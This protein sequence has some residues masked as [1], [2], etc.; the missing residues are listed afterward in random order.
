[1]TYINNYAN[2][3][4]TFEIDSE[5]EVSSLPTH[6]KNNVGYHSKAI[7]LATGN[8]YF[9]EESSDTWQLFGGE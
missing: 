1:M 2:Q 5:A 8:V 7:V 4:R 9:L 6:T 3:K